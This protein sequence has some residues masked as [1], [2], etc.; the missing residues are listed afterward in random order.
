VIAYTTSLTGVTAAHLRGGFF[1]GWPNPPA[2]ETHLRLLHAA[3]HVVL[4]K[5]EEQVVGFVTA[6]SD[7]I[8]TAYIP[9]LEVLPAWRGRGIG[10][11]LVRRMIAALSPIYMIDLV[12][13]EAVVPFYQRLGMIHLHGMAFRHYESQSGLPDTGAEPSP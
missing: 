4:A 6:L 7:G 8:L 1:E 10:G 5:H 11:E 12:C 3:S 13:D 2:P 9:H